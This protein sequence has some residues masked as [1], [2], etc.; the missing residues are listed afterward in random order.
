MKR[1]IAFMKKEAVLVV[2]VILAVISA[3]AVPP[4]AAYLEYIDWRVLGILLSLM[5]IM[6]GLQKNGLF[7]AIGNRLLQKTKNTMQLSMVL[8][9]LC[10][11]SS[12]LITN[13]VALI[14]FVPF[15]IFTLQKSK[16]DKLAIPVIVLQ[17]VAANLGSMLTPIGNPQNLYLYNLAE[18]TMAEFVQWMLPYTVVSGVLLLFGVLWIARRKEPIH[19][20]L[21][22]KEDNTASNSK[23]KTLHKNVV[24]L[25]LFALSLMVVMRLLPYYLVLILIVLLVFYMDRSVLKQVDYCLLFTF[26][27]FFIFTGNMGNITA[28][29]EML[30]SLVSG[31]E[32]A[33][34]VAASQFISNVPAALLLSGFTSDYGALLVGV[35]LGGLGTLIASMASLISYKIYGNTYGSSKGKYLL[36]FTLVNILFLVVLL[37]LVLV[38]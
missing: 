21:V 33:V 32:V 31:R 9:F 22:E 25:T 3:F 6:A 35:N 27:A 16:Q 37:A 30:Q 2:A 17:T 34:G 1:I 28:I 8:V 14:T 29:N 5:I 12:M 26:I 7:D 13:D 24:Y 10:F 19:D 38:V 18:M 23:W 15:A 36:A 4:T 20:I 11:F